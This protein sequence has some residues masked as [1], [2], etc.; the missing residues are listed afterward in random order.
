MLHKLLVAYSGF[1]ILSEIILQQQ[2]AEAHPFLDTALEALY[3]I[4][5][6]R[7]LQHTP[8]LGALHSDPH[9]QVACEIVH[10]AASIHAEENK[11]L[12]VLASAP[13]PPVVVSPHLHEAPSSS[14]TPPCKKARITRE[15]DHSCCYH[16]ACEMSPPDVTFA[17]SGSSLSSGKDHTDHEESLI[18]VALFPAHRQVMGGASDVFAALLC[19]SFREA[20]EETVRLLDV[21][22]SSFEVLLH[23]TY[24]CR[25]KCKQLSA[26]TAE[27]AMGDSARYLLSSVLA[28]ADRYMMVE[29]I[30][31]SER[32]LLRYVTTESVLELF[33]LA[34]LHCTKELQHCC[35]ELV[36]GTG[37]EFC[38]E[39]GHK[40]ISEGLMPA[41]LVVFQQ[42][43]GLQ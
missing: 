15:T 9:L 22:P 41:A 7:K 37:A 4:W 2:N 21:E 23:H 36:F 33:S 17:V 18:A 14:E 8:E 20:N 32:A 43:A 26:Y 30:S 1:T 38:I 31:D 29:L 6:T 11:S 24:G 3:A 13:R 34:T 25:D 10:V 40:L 39:L 27:T 28:I 19:G 42:L 35:I 16:Q 5:Q 12:P